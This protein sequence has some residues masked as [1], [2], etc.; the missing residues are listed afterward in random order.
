[1]GILLQE[2]GAVLE[3]KTKKLMRKSKMFSRICYLTDVE[4]NWNYVQNYLTKSKGLFVDPK[5]QQLALRDDFMFVFG[6]DAGDKGNE[7]LRFVL[8]LFDIS[9]EPSTTLMTK[10]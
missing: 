2:S 8:Y 10:N 5:S 9:F 7:T 1:M 4:G 3:K 6:G